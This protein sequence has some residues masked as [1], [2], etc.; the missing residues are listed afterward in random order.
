MKKNNWTLLILIVSGLLTGTILA[1]A[2]NV[3]TGWSF[4]IQG[5]DLNWHPQANWG[6]IHFELN[7]GVQL[8]VGSIVGVIA[9][10]WMF[11]RW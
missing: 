2:F 7:F 11:R 8:N 9:A 1:H 6:F 10:I 5:L 3:W 4:L